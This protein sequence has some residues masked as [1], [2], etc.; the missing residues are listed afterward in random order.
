MSANFS[1]TCLWDDGKEESFVST[2]GAPSEATVQGVPVLSF[3]GTVGG[4]GNVGPVKINLNK[5]RYWQV[6]P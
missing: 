3:Q 1:I 4:S 2:S 5:V 6:M